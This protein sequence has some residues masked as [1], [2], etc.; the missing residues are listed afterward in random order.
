ML[1]FDSPPSP[2]H[3]ISNSESSNNNR[4][5]S[6]HFHSIKKLILI[7]FLSLILLIIA[8]KIYLSTKINDKQED[9]DHSPITHHTSLA[10][11]TVGKRKYSFLDFVLSIN[12]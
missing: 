8:I 6:N 7:I 3:R 11:E 12:R 1:D 2:Y 10:T 9:H 4:Y 5:I